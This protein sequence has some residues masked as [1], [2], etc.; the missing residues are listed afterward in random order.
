MADGIRVHS[1]IHAPPGQ[2][3]ITKIEP[4]SAKSIWL[5]WDSPVTGSSCTDYEVEV[6]DQTRRKHTVIPANVKSNLR[7]PTLQI[8]DLE[9]LQAY[10]FRVRGIV[11]Q[12]CARLAEGAWSEPFEASTQFCHSK[13]DQSF[14]SF[15]PNFRKRAPENGNYT[16]EE[17][18]TCEK[19]KACTIQ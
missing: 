18:S 10:S 19:C 7:N 16:L 17:E 5:K 13:E 1:D 4:I 2:P 11:E 3:R 8:D 12:G 6:Y 9:Q 15:Q 14:S